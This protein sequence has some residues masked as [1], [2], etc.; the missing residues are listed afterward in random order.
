MLSFGQ[1]FKSACT[2]FFFSILQ[3]GSWREVQAA[4]V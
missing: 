4:E 1:L 3:K 2:L